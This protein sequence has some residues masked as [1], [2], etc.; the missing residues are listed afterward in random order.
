M[1]F[2]ECGGKALRDTALVS[3]DNSTQSA[4]A[5]PPAHSKRLQFGNSC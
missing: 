3:E 5:A 2:M 1:I 4:V